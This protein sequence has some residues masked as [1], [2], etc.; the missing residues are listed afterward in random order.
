MDE[1]VIGIEMF[2]AEAIRVFLETALAEIF[3]AS[4]QQ[5]KASE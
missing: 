4:G 3:Y 1:I 2:E 5:Q